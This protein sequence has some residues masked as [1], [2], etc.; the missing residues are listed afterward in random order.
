MGACLRK[1]MAEIPHVSLRSATPCRICVHNESTVRVRLCWIDY[2]GHRRPYALLDPRS[3]WEQA[4][5]ET[6]P[7]CFDVHG[8]DGQVVVCAATLQQVVYPA[9]TP[10]QQLQ[11]I[12]LI[13]APARPW[14]P[15]V[16]SAH[17]A[18]YSQA[19]RTVLLCHHRLAALS[20]V[21]ST[22]SDSSDEEP[23]AYLMAGSEVFTLGFLPNALILHLLELAAPNSPIVRRP[24]LPAGSMPEDYTQVQR[25]ALFRDENA[26]EA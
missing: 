16:H 13:N 24:L 9:A 15:E 10:G 18:A 12:R 7:W 5:F 25:D 4:T 19:A 22:A 21:N 26:E 6:H 11:H 14:T 1:A 8:A 2:Q 17:F 20:P 23:G 3:T